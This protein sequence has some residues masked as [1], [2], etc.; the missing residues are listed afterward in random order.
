MNYFRITTNS[1]VVVGV[2]CS[3]NPIYIRRQE[4]N[5]ILVR[6]GANEAQGLVSEKD[7][8]TVYKLDG[9]EIPGLYNDELLNAETITLADYEE[10]ITTHGDDDIEDVI[11]EVPEDT[12]EEEILTR[13]EL[14]A[15]VKELEERNEFLEDC[16]LEMS[17]EIYA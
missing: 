12:Q 8:D 10:Y 15:R 9:N 3:E 6:C 4:R 14:T 17:E 16:L 7:N 2:E 5:G 13:A 11:P 1:G